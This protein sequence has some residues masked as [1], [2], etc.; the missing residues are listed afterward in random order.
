M[1]KLA[2]ENSLL[3]LRVIEM[4]MKLCPRNFNDEQGNSLIKQQKNFFKF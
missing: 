2:T 4:C 3:L 1:K